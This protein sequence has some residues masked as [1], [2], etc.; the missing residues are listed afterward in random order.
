MLIVAAL[1]LFIVAPAR[2]A[3]QAIGMNLSFAPDGVS[4]TPL[5]DD[6][7]T[8]GVDD[9]I[10]TFDKLGGEHVGV[11]RFYAE[12]CSLEPNAPGSPSQWGNGA[13]KHL[14]DQAAAAEQHQLKPLIDLDTSAPGFARYP[15]MQGSPPVSGCA[16]PP[17]VSNPPNQ[18]I[19]PPGFNF[20]PWYNNS[21]VPGW[22]RDV[23]KE[24]VF[25]LMGLPTC[26]VQTHGDLLNAG[27]Y[28]DDGSGS[29]VSVPG[30]M[31]LELGNEPNLSGHWQTGLCQGGNTNWTTGCADPGWIRTVD[32]DQYAAMADQAAAGAHAAAT[33]HGGDVKVA[34]A[35][36]NFPR[37][38]AFPNQNINP[39][40]YLVDIYSTQTP[41]WDAVGI[42]PYPGY[43]PDGGGADFAVNTFQQDVT[44]VDQWVHQAFSDDAAIW[45]TEVGRDSGDITGT[46]INSPLNNPLPC[47]EPRQRDELT[48]I[49]AAAAYD[50]PAPTR[51]RLL[52]FYNIQDSQGAGPNMGVIHS[53]GHTEKPAY[54]ALSNFYSSGPPTC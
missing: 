5:V 42:H 8:P 22:Y 31:G 7:D 47:T 2:A 15:N 38:D 54:T 11:V 26:P 29:P 45:V 6:P 52:A 19:L 37:N 48:S 12:W 18:D 53:D 51:L 21:S 16:P 20:A 27:T 4:S 17:K 25:C 1:G 9:S 46:C 43:P 50:C 34:T 39:L 28:P 10:A 44:S 36:L 33:N 32:A 41:D 13:F 30:I 23:A 49:A 3:V 14:L 40:T 24:V 35:G